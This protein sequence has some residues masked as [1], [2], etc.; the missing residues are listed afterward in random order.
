M[1]TVDCQFSTQCRLQRHTAVFT[2]YSTSHRVG[3]IRRLEAIRDLKPSTAEQ[4]SHLVAQLLGHTMHSLMLSFSKIIGFGSRFKKLIPDPELN[5]HKKS[6]WLLSP[7]PYS[8][9][10]TILLKS[11]HNLLIR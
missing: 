7:W 9:F 3:L 1:Q 10:R 6:Q 8:F 2:D 5:R 11:V 4:C